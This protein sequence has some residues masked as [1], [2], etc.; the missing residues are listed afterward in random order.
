MRFS[1]SM[2]AA[3]GLAS[4]AVPV[5]AQDE[6]NE[7]PILDNGLTDIVQWSDP[8]LNGVTAPVQR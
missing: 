1:R 4:L 5:W 8:L 7:W 3:A 6:G 2:L